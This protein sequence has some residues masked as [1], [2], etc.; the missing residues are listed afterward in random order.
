MSTVSA[1]ILEAASA[2]VI[3][4]SKNAMSCLRTASR[5][6]DRNRVDCLSPATV[7][8]DT[9]GAGKCSRHQSFWILRI[10]F[11]QE[12]ICKLTEKGSNCCS[13]SQ[14]DVVHGNL[15]KLKQMFIDHGLK[16]NILATPE[17]LFRSVSVMI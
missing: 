11:L 3:S 15:Q 2:V 12:N 4:T 5:Y 17:T 8:Q 7:Q 16:G 6:N 10:Q 9:S 13:D 1:D 14:I